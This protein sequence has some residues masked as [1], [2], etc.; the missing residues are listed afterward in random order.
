MAVPGRC[1]HWNPGTHPSNPGQIGGRPGKLGGDIGYRKGVGSQ[2][3]G[4][5]RVGREI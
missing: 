1:L 3:K 2:E 4:Q 5:A